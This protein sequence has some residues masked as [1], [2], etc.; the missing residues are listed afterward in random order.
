MTEEADALFALAHSAD[1]VA[2]VGINGGLKTHVAGNLSADIKS[3][4]HVLAKRRTRLSLALDG[5][6]SGHFYKIVDDIVT[7]FL[8]KCIDFLL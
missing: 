2:A 3:L 6:D 7:V 4:C 8:Q 5:G 1:C